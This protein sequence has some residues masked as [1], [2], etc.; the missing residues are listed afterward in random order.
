M[1]AHQK[2][3]S[4]SR[5]TRR[6]RDLSFHVHGTARGLG[7]GGSVALPPSGPAPALALELSL[8]S[9]VLS[10]LQLVPKGPPKTGTG[11][12]RESW[13]LIHVSDCC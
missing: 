13:D 7:Q 11:V 6:E 8:R 5:E 10:T 3:S 1:S 4:S 2:A 9:V 12:W